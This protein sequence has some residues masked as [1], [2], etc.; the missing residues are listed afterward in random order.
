MCVNKREGDGKAQPQEV[1]TARED[2]FKYVDSPSV[3]KR[4][5]SSE[6]KIRVQA[7]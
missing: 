7:K 4:E 3:S 6:V 2:E 5:C 1:E